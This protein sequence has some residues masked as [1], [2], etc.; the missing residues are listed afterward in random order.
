MKQSWLGYCVLSVFC[1][2]PGCAT[3]SRP[4]VE[5]QNDA[6]AF[7]RLVKHSVN[8]YKRHY[9]A[10]NLLDLLTPLAVAGTLANTNADTYIRDTWQ[11]DIRSEFTDDVGRIFLEAG[12]LGQNKI[13]LPVYA[14]TMLATDYTGDPETDSPI[15]T[16]AAR[17]LRAN[18]LGGPQAWTL[19][20][21]LGSHRPGVGESDWNPWNDNDGVSGHAFYGAVPFLT[22]A[23]MAE[24]PGW[25]Y[26]LYAISALPSI[27]RINNNQHYASQVVLGWSVAWLATRTI[28]EVPTAERAFTIMPLLTPDGG[29]LV[30]I[31][32][33]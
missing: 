13:S 22:A 10:D 29:S 9:G 20:Y 5:R 12:D 7:S 30:L 28:A 24:S 8:D 32:R 18:V 21:V 3:Q 15:A 31:Y 11:D 33:F 14:L 25:R 2:L 23:R 19:T 4:D 17:S 1:L 6:G 16:W 26:S 27:S